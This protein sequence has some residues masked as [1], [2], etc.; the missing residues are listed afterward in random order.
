MPDELPDAAKEDPDPAVLVLQCRTLSTAAEHLELM[1]E[2]DVLQGELSAG[3]E[4]GVQRKKND[5]EHQ[6]MLIPGSHNRND[7]NRTEFLVATG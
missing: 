5:F 4:R 6:T 2:G 1:T 3:F 7:T